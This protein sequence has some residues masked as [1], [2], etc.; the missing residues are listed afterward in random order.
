MKNK[1]EKEMNSFQCNQSQ[2]FKLKLHH[3]MLSAFSYQLCC[4]PSDESSGPSVF[5]VCG[6]PAS[7]HQQTISVRP[8]S[9]PAQLAQGPF[10]Q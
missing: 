7:S 5:T 6:H 8:T 1:T 3:S 2:S 4:Q 9:Q 10:I